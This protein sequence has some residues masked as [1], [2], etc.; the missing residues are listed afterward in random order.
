MGAALLA[1]MSG[2]LILPVAGILLAGRALGPGALEWNGREIHGRARRILVL[3]GVVAA[4]G[5]LALL[6]IWGAYGFRYSAT[7]GPGEARETL[8]CSLDQELS[9]AGRMAPVLGLARELRVLPE[10]YLYGF[11]YS[12]THAGSRRAFMAGEYSTTGWPGF[13]PFAVAV[14][15]PM[16]AFLVMALAGWGLWKKRRAFPFSRLA[17]LAALFLV[18]GGFSLASHINIGHR[19]V[20]PL[21]PVAFILAGGAVLA[22]GKALRRSAVAL[23]AVLVLFAAESVAAWPNYLAFFNLASGGPAQGYRLL[24]DSSLDWGQD[25]PALKRWLDREAGKDRD[26]VPV[27]LS[28]FGSASPRY[29]GLDPFFLPSYCG[30]A[31]FEP[32]RAEPLVLTGGIYCISATLF[33][34]VYTDTFGRWCE[35]YERA[36]QVSRKV[37]RKWAGTLKDPEAARAFIREM[38]GEERIRACL[39]DHKRLR[40]GRICHR[41]GQRKPDAFAGFSILIFKVYFEELKGML[42]GPAGEL[43]RDPGIQGPVPEMV[44]K[45]L[46]YPDPLGVKGEE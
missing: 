36:Y 26:H 22:A 16:A 27:Y 29:Y 19:H 3:A 8:S 6:V 40:F 4:Q 34:Q 20:L 21:Y 41:L 12:L 28:F 9:A 45:W 11:T 15:T 18:Y 30:A 38:G 17:P 14:K 2:V 31:V 1:K 46:N 5:L 42:E 39:D 44:S 37:F 33:Q 7:A 25:L 10:A 23:A 13:F 32:L 43:P 35:P 24:V